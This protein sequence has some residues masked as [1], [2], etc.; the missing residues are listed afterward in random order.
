MR[1]EIGVI[2]GVGP[3]ATA[4][5]LARVVAWTDA[6]SDQEH[7]DLVVLQHSSIPDRTA[8]IVGTSE[9]SPA[10]VLAAD[11]ARLE[12]LGVAA[13]VVPCNTA[14]AFIGAMREAVT[15]DVIDIVETAI[16][17]AL[18]AGATRIGVLSTAGTR[19]AGSYVTAA[20]A[21]GAE[22]IH[23]DEDAQ[24]ALNRLIYE[25]VKA[26]LPADPD[27]YDQAIADVVSRG[28]DVVILGCTELSVAA[29]QIGPRDRVLD[30]LDSL[31]KVTIRLA[32]CA[33]KAS[34]E[35]ESQGVASA[36]PLA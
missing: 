34:G 32:G 17:D 29:S 10:P 16:D 24:A 2:G 4:E 14:T 35:G 1:Q 26:G 7:A 11:A 23:P 22:V 9:V 27:L 20:H 25:Q 12:R 15:I 19:A 13:V 36:P 21:R 31:A 30:S 33:V 8:F 5:F 28:A 18:A 3:A 6:G